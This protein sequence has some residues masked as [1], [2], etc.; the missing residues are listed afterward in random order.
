M[1]TRMNTPVDKLIFFGG[2]TAE[3]RDRLAASE[4]FAGVDFN[5]AD[6]QESNRINFISVNLP[7]ALAGCDLV[8][9][10]LEPDYEHW[11]KERQLDKKTRDYEIAKHH[12][13]KPS[14]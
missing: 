12:C 4:E 13:W 6:N 3:I 10:R 7:V 14:K 2:I 11:L 8:V 9:N 1:R 5:L